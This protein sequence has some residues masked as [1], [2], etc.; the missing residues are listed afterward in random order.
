MSQF[1]A[2]LP[3]RQQ[4]K[5]AP[6]PQHITSVYVTSCPRPRRGE[7]ARTCGMPISFIQLHN[8]CTER[9]ANKLDGGLLQ[10]PYDISLF[11][12]A[13]NTWTFNSFIITI[14][15][16]LP[17]YSNRF[18]DHVRQ[19]LFHSKHPAAAQSVILLMHNIQ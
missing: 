7:R 18:E 5:G 11:S 1:K 8:R 4:Q 16:P 13:L 15:S 9:L 10:Y 19:N 6:A 2:F 17:N 14:N 3:D 12:L